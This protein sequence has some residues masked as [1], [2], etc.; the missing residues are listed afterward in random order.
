VNPGRCL[1][2]VVVALTLLA[3]VPADAQEGRILDREGIREVVEAHNEARRRFALPPLEWDT[4]LAEQ[5][6]RCIGENRNR[7]FRHCDSSFGENMYGTTGIPEPAR[8]VLSWM[9]EEALYDP[10]RARCEDF[11]CGHFSQVVWSE[12][13]RVGCAVG[14]G[15]RGWTNL[16][17]N[18]DPPG[19]FGYMGDQEGRRTP[20]GGWFYFDPPP[21]RPAGGAGG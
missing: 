13:R 9:D 17:C 6:L 4:A 14:P 2:A 12:T 11:A 19:N 16:I 21:F 10:V 5:A 15:E 18:Y 7:R 8:A 20:D 1:R 3:P